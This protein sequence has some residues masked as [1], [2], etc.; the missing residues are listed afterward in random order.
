MPPRVALPLLFGITLPPLSRLRA[1]LPKCHIINP[2]N[3]AT[4]PESYRAFVTCQ[5]FEA[6]G[7]AGNA[8]NVGSI[9]S[10]VLARV[11]G[12]M[13]IHFV[14][15]PTALT[16]LTNNVVGAHDKGPQAMADLSLHYINMF[17]R[18]CEWKIFFG[19]IGN[20]ASNAYVLPLYS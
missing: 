15:T 13:L 4:Q 19:C 7:N 17:I 5:A 9:N 1:S 3:I 12:Y 2:F 14:E 18:C 10:L 16:N 8:L 11:C 20:G 6:A